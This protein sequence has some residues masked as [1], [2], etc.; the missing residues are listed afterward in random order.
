MEMTCLAQS[1]D[2]EIIYYVG[3]HCTR[4]STQQPMQNYSLITLR[5]TLSSSS[6]TQFCASQA[7]AAMLS[8]IPLIPMTMSRP[9]SSRSICPVCSL[10]RESRTLSSAWPGNIEDGKMYCV[11]YYV[12]SRCIA[13]LRIAL[14]RDDSSSGVERA[15]TLRRKR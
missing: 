13:R 3:S 11:L 10:P 2:A 4:V 7:A 1:V 14:W 6:H 8:W 12:Y 5:L 9:R 15:L